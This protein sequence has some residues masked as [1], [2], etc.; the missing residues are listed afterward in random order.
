MTLEIE[1]DSVSVRVCVCERQCEGEGER[2]TERLNTGNVLSEKQA[3]MNLVHMSH[4]RKPKTTTG[5]HSPRFRHKAPI[6]QQSQ[7]PTTEETT[8][9]LNRNNPCPRTKI[10]QQRDHKQ[11]L[12]TK[13]S[14][15]VLR[16]KRSTENE[17]ER[18]SEK[19]RGSK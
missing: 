18:E 11:V 6:I 1:I 2:A 13:R 16:A 3:N 15:E 19:V 14:Q 7:D 5:L 10:N 8:N 4:S 17:R 12:T 9:Q